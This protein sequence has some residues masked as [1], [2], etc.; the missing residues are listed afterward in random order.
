MPPGRFQMHA[1]GGLGCC[2]ETFKVCEKRR[3]GKERKEREKREKRGEKRKE[4]EKGGSLSVQCTF[5][6]TVSL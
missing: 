5:R 6:S 4:R 1:G 3:E 2:G